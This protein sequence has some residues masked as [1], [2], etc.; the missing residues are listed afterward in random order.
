[1]TSS[2]TI[3]T[4]YFDIGRGEWTANKGFRDK[5]ARSV[6][7]YFN[8]FER[9]AA[10]E[11]DMVIFTSP[12]LKS[13][14]E[15]LRRGKPTTVIAIDIK[16]KFKYIRRRIERVQQDKAFTDKLEP[17]QL[18]NPEYWSPDYVLVCNLKSYF[19]NK[20][21]HLDLIKTPM[22]A[23]IDFGYCRKPNVLRGLKVWD[24]PFD[25]NKM[26]LFTIKKGLRVN[27]QQQVFDFMIGNHVY[28][29][30][31]ALVGSQEKWMEFYPLVT[32]SQK[33]TLQN[34]IVDD[35]QGIF[36]MCYYKRPDLFQLN[37]LGRR[38]WFDLFRCFKRTK[39]GSKLQAFRILLSGK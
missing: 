25:R 21:I 33:I 10:L 15:N 29:I 39:L 18:K 35:D 1:M 12:E 30:G 34:N 19:V 27:S 23:W 32:K 20:A 6:D 9:L 31:G 24:F 4:A 17:R 3:V 8:Y 37:Y 22:V 2:T 5:L 26:H 13:K 36:V 7:V 38:K 16:N 14:V 11:N 28:I